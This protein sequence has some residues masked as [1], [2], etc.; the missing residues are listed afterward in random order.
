MNTL[1]TICARIGSKGLKNKNLKN[2]NGKPLIFY[3]IDQAIKSKIFNKIVVST[4]SKIIRNIALKY[5][6]ISLSL[7]SEDLSNDLTAKI[8]VIKDVHK[9]SEIFFKQNFDHIIDLDVTSPLRNVSD[10][11]QS[12]L[13]F[14]KNNSDN[15]LSVCE[16][17]KNPYFNMIEYQNGKIQRVKSL[18]Y[19]IHARQQAPQVYDMN[20]S[21]YI[22]KKKYLYS[23]NPFFRKNTFLYKM[24][25]DRSIDIDTYSDWKLVKLL[26]NEQKKN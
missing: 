9:E 5:G 11:R 2:L 19:K 8:D 18:K 6:A 23:K 15:L 14:I 16:A 12:Y 20:A 26:K 10:I 22:W 3:T 1:C 17:R 13:S 7:R 25:F 21:I 24:P 4:D